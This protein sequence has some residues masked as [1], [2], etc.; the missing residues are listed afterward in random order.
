[1]KPVYRCT[2]EGCGAIL[3]GEIT[4]CPV[5]PAAEREK[6]GVELHE[7]PAVDERERNAERHL[8]ALEELG[9]A[10]DLLAARGIGLHRVNG[11]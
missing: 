10:D 2:A 3:I 5:H 1:M 9:D 4:D 6:I 8:I 7:V 11:G